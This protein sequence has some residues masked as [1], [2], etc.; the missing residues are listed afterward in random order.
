[1]LLTRLVCILSYSTFR[2]TQPC[3]NIS[4]PI[5]LF[6]LFAYQEQI[7]GL[8]RL[9]LAGLYHINDAVLDLIASKLSL[10]HIN[11]SG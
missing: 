11:L 2:C 10:T 7:P 3:Q 1:M 4:C 8:R 6:G 9:D 5:L